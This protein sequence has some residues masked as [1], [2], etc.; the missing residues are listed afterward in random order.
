MGPGD[1][2]ETDAN[3]CVVRVVQRSGAKVLRVAATQEGAERFHSELHPILETLGVNH[4]WHRIGF[5]SVELDDVHLPP[6]LA[7]YLEPRAEKGALHYEF[8]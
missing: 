2:V 6:E 5:V 1:E 4:E 3:F 8:A 7:A